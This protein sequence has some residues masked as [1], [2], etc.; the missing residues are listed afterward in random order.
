MKMYHA[1][2]PTNARDIL[3]NGLEVDAAGEAGYTQVYAQWADQLY[4]MRPVFLSIKKG[5][6]AGIPLLVDTTGIPLVADLAAIADLGDEP[7][8]M[9]D[10]ELIWWDG[11][12]PPELSSISSDGAV[13]I[14]SLLIPGSKEAEL[15]IRVTG[16]AAVLED[17]PPDR[18]KIATYNEASLREYIREVLNEEV[19][20]QTVGSV[21]DALG[22]I[23]DVDDE[24]Q[25]KERMKQLA[26]K[27]GWEMVKFIPVVGK[28]IKMAKTIGDIYKLAKD[29]PDDLA[30]KDNVVLDMLD[31][32][33]KYQQMLDDRLE[34]AFDEVVIPWLES[35]PPDAPLPDMN[36]KLEAWVNQ[37][38]D[39]RGIHGA[40]GG[41]SVMKQEN[42][43]LSLRQCVKTMLETGEL[44]R[45]IFS[46]RAP[47]GRHM[48][49]ERDT[50]LEG[51]I[52]TALWGHLQGLSSK[53]PTN[54]LDAMV[55]FSKD[56]AYN[57]VFILH[58]SGDAY[59]GMEVSQ[60]YL[61]EHA[62]GWKEATWPT[63]KLYW[64]WSDV[65]PVDFEY[66]NRNESR[67]VSSWTP[68]RDVAEQFGRAGHGMVGVVLIA[69]SATNTFLDLKELYRFDR[70]D[71]FHW[72][73]EIVGFGSIRV[74]G[75][76]ILKKLGGFG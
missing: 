10:G 18:I 75:I 46:D 22:V 76:K 27:I 50:E 56:P 19:G 62:P 47:L 21:L 67:T 41:D 35:L 13:G 71:D 66:Q 26:K 44:G 59:R 4:G 70:L 39:E 61:D 24:A 29:T 54:L 31:V 72:E 6:F 9:E 8:S 65:I 68:S 30:T 52:W 55:S 63:S 15:A 7:P 57:D 3:T 60:E 73:E 49:S 25:R 14:E 12:G 43:E 33:D 28:G 36:D 20:R 42:I 38:F 32:D 23:K 51:E 16:T 45:Q 69:D 1:T 74:K 53:V 37:N 64:Q 17:I 2:S 11:M 48:G 40:A 34:A 58:T 5:K